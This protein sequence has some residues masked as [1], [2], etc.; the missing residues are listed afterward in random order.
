MPDAAAKRQTRDFNRG[1]ACITE[2]P[3]R[4]FAMSE[5]DLLWYNRKPGPPKSK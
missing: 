4:F 1:E 3:R 2:T 5:K